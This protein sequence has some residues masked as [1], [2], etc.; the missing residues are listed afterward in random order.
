MS[1]A[2]DPY[3][4]SCRP[5]CQLLPAAANCVI[6]GE[7]SVSERGGRNG[8]KTFGE[9]HEKPSR[10]YEHQLGHSPV[11]AETATPHRHRS[12]RRIL[13]VRLDA[14]PATSATSAAPR[15]VD[16]NGLANFQARDVRTERMDP[17][18]VLVSERKRRSPWQQAF[19]EFAHQMQVRVTRTR[20]TDTNHHLVP[21][22]NGILHFH[23]NRVRL[24]LHES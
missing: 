18:R 22:W 15:A 8:V 19:S 17:S 1:E 24:P 23:Q 12:R 3:D 11:Q 4:D 6:G 2:S 13:T 14:E 9:R 5:W 21:T 7:A 10:G 20:T 16:G